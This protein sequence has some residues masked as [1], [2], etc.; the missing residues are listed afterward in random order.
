[1]N[2]LLWAL[3]AV[4]AVVYLAHGWMLLFPPATMVNMIN[5]SIGPRFRVFIGVAEVLASVGLI[6]PGLTH[7]PAWLTP[8]AA[9]GLMIVMASATV[10]HVQR[11]E[12][13]PAIVCVVLLG[14]V[15][16]VAYMRW[17]VHPLVSRRTVAAA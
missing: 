15:T 7:I 17:A 4:L 10:F 2:R 13:P 14:L 5:A 9:A 1:M 6:V 3:Q 8:L 11:G 12:I 16:F